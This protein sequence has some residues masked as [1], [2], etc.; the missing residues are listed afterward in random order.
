[1]LG[2]ND[3]PSMTILNYMSNFDFDAPEE[4][5]GYRELVDKWL[6][7]IFLINQ[8]F[9]KLSYCCRYSLKLYLDP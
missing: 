6:Y 3:G 2:G 5:K 1:M 4:W 9:L 7:N 8:L